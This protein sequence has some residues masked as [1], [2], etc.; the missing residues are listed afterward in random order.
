MGLNTTPRTWTTA[1]LVTAAMLNTEVRDAL[2]GIQAAWTAYTPT[3]GS[4]G[5]QP[6]LGNG[7]LAGAYMQIGKTIHFR[8]QLTVGSTST[9][10]TGNYTLTLPV[11][12]VSSTA[13]R[14]RFEGWI[15]D[16]SA[17]ALYDLRASS[18]TT[19][20][21]NLFLDATTAAIVGAF[22]PTSPVTLATSDVVSLNG[23]YEAA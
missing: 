7:T 23:T 11:M 12:P 9:F 17:G 10:G 2:T 19:T 5:T 8:C 15:F 4:G 22:T 16:N 13:Q 3:W 1:E 18:T 6:T 20:T 21:M 14:H